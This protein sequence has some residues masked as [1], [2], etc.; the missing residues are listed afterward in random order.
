MKTDDELRAENQAIRERLAAGAD[1]RLRG[2][3]GVIHVSVGLKEKGGA[4]TDQL[5]IRV[6]VR[7]KRDR[8][9][10]APDEVIP[11]EISG[12][13]T[14]VNLVGE[15]DFQT[16]NTRYRPIKGGIQISNRILVSAGAGGGTQIARGTLG[17]LAID[18]TDNAAV[19]LSSSHV[20]MANGA[21][22]GDKVFQ[23][24]PVWLPP[25][26]PQ[27]VP[28]RPTD[29]A[30]KIA[31][32]R[33][34]VMT[35]KADAAI[36]AIDVSSCCHCCGIHFSNDINGLS[37]AGQPPRNTIVGDERAVSGMRVFKVGHATLRTEGTV[38]DDNYPDFSITEGATSH[39]F[40]GQIAVQNTDHTQPFSIHGDSGAVLINASNKIVGL[41]FAGG[42]NV[43]VHGAPQPF[44]TLANHISDVFTALNIR[45]PYAQDVVVTAGERL[46]DVPSVHEAPIPEPYRAL[47]QRLLRHENTAR[48]FALGERHADEV[49]QLVNHCKPV[50]I[51]WHKSQGPA[52]LATVMGAIR[53]GHDQL[54]AS[55]KGVAP[56]EA[57]ERMRAALGQYGSAALRDHFSRTEVA[58]LIDQLKDCTSIDEVIE[59][60]A[61]DHTLRALLREIDR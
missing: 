50:T 24:G 34:G 3:P 25:V 9:E 2:I 19:L 18:Q 7:R 42:R 32:I 29:D 5:C 6:Y 27:P 37:A 28:L 47:R 26:M 36:A 59:R 43:A 14:D 60:I 21:A 13:A 58:P 1:A 35:N 40:T 31:V 57:V 22:S 12:I 52:L 30:D 51:A 46:M 8:A 41:I 53:D 54:P 17:C 20:L 56:H 45:I 15:F 23:P 61:K 16:D 38:V 4:L 49:T 11:L 39:P 33:R 55:V 48:L 10:I 44:V